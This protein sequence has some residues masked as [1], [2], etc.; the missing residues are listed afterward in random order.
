VSE[1]SIAR[2]ASSGILILLIGI[3]IFVFVNGVLMGAEYTPYSVTVNA[4]TSFLINTTA[5]SSTSESASSSTSS[6]ITTPS[7]SIASGSINFTSPASGSSVGVLQTLA[8][9]GSVIPTPTQPD[10]VLIVANQFNA[11]PVVTTTMTVG[12]DGKLT[13]STTVATNGTPRLYII[14][15]TDLTGI[16]GTPGFSIEKATT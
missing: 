6:I 5:S 2:K 12:S 9:S 10:R 4:T 3:S 14:T 11:M 13:Y 15:V 7:S 8:I 16:S 1:D